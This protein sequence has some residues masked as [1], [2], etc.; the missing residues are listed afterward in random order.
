MHLNLPSCES[1]VPWGV[2]VQPGRAEYKT[3]RRRRR[4]QRTRDPRRGCKSSRCSRQMCTPGRA[5][6]RAAGTGGRRATRAGPTGP[7]GPRLPRR[8]GLQAWPALRPTGAERTEGAE[9]HLER[10]K[11]IRKPTLASTA[12][13]NT[14][15]H[16]TSYWHLGLTWHWVF[17]LYVNVCIML[18]WVVY[19]FLA[20]KWYYSPIYTSFF[21]QGLLHLTST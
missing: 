5:P 21:I 4:R 14:G 16:A 17:I 15:A 6:R 8:W 9:R 3:L 11:S 18:D 10:F 12:C 7:G 19:T 13:V 1:W 20:C 2:G